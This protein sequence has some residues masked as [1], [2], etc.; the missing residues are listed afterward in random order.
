MLLLIRLARPA[1]FLLLILPGGETA[2]AQQCQTFRRCYDLGAEAKEAGSV[3]VAIRYYGMACAT[4]VERVYGA[5][6]IAAC[7]SIITLSGESD[8]Y[9][10]A[11]A[12]FGRRCQG[13]SDQA[14]FFMGRIAEERDSLRAALAI[15]RPLCDERFEL[16]AVHGY[17]ACSHVRRIEST[18]D[19]RHPDVERTGPI[20]SAAFFSI[21]A[22]TAISA[23]AFLRFLVSKK[24]GLAAASVGSAVLAL[25]SY[26][27]YESGIPSHYAIRV[28]L[29]LIFPAL[30]VNLALIVAAA[31]GAALVRRKASR[32]T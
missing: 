29:L 2:A 31:V 10:R 21:F 14:C 26:G 22:M 13:G 16:P 30:V 15:M 6:Q 4:P 8:D 3:D 17:D 18:T 12:Y 23:L 5:L 24:N 19:A 1:T 28:D 32:T 25:L 7:E 9:A 11:D 20:Q 27:Y